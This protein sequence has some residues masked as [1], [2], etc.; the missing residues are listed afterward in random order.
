MVVVVLVTPGKSVVVEVVSPVVL[1]VDDVLVVVVTVVVVSHD[2]EVSSSKSQSSLTLQHAKYSWFSPPGLLLSK[3]VLS[4][5]AHSRR[6]SAHWPLRQAR[7][8]FGS[9]PVADP[10]LCTQSE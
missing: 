6:R 8:H 7:V 1:V 3:S 5:G 2:S 4:F 10:Q 9:A